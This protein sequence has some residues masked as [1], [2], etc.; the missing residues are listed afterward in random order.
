MPPFKKI[1]LPCF[2]P[3]KR[4]KSL[5][6]SSKN[7]QYVDS[8]SP[9][10][11]NTEN[12][13]F[14]ELRGDQT[15][16]E[17]PAVSPMI[18]GRGFWLATS[19]PGQVITTGPGTA[20]TLEFITNITLN[21]GWTFIGTPYDF[22]VD[23]S[24]ITTSTGEALDI[25]SFQGSWANHIGPLVP[26]QGY[27]VASVGGGQLEVNPF[28]VTTTKTGSTPGKSTDPSAAYDWALRLSAVSESAVDDD[29]VIAIAREASTGWDRMDRP[30]PPV[31]G[32]YISLYF[33]HPDWDVPFDRFNTDVRASFGERESWLF[34]VQTVVDEPI[35]LSVDGFDS[36]PA[37][38]EI[39]LIDH[40]LH[41]QQDLKENASYTFRAGKND[42]KE[43]F[44]LI[45]GTPEAVLNDRAARHEI[46]DAMH[47][48]AFPN[49]FS[50]FT[51]LEFGLPEEAIVSIEVYDVLGKRVATLVEG[52]TR[53]AGNHAVQW[54]GR[55]HSGQAVANGVYLLS[56]QTAA[57]RAVRQV[58]VVR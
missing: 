17:Y 13:R 52:D 48:Q 3:I 1:L 21:A 43:R 41:H 38:L 18:R 49:P 47:L 53:E 28:L 22:S 8:F 36:M 32:N 27:A 42:M 40:M 10:A 4:K 56:V 33:P 24:Q 7:N 30:E 44:E 9:G 51:T 6:T 11:Y 35:T 5:Q 50:T 25:R 55:D 15:Y 34:E 45:V 12:W 19:R 57:E 20:A 23:Q 2:F 46:P 31:I 54:D 39:H 29:N 16:G 26:F 14:F 37:S 58:V